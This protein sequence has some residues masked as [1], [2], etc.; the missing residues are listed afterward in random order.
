MTYI[1]RDDAIKTIRAALRRRSG[2][3][4]SV[5]HDRG[6]ASGWI[7]ICAPPRRCIAGWYMTPEDMAELEKLLGFTGTKV[8]STTG[9]FF[10]PHRREEYIERAEGRLIGGA[11]E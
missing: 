4:W 11:D 10:D 7:E 9:I 3:D 8:H 1:D 2:K 6:T 5:R